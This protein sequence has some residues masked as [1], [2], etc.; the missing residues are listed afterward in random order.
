MLLIAEESIPLKGF[1]S[2]FVLLRNYLIFFSLQELAVL[3]R[4]QL[5]V[6]LERIFL[7]YY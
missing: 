5:L 1:A 4:G 3:S 6:S 2:S 7:K